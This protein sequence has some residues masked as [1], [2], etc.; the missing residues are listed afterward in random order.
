MKVEPGSDGLS[1]SLFPQAQKGYMKLAPSATGTGGSG[2]LKVY[3][4]VMDKET[5]TPFAGE[6]GVRLFPQNWSQAPDKVSDLDELT[7]SM[8]GLVVGVPHR[9]SSKD[10]Q[11]PLQLHG[12]QTGQLFAFEFEDVQREDVRFSELQ[13]QVGSQ[14]IPLAYNQDSGA[15]AERNTLLVLIYQDQGRGHEVHVHALRAKGDVIAST[16]RELSSADLQNI[17]NLTTFSKLHTVALKSGIEEAAIDAAS[18]KH[19]GDPRLAGYELLKEMKDRLEHFTAEDLAQLFDDDNQKPLAEKIRSGNLQLTFEDVQLQQEMVMV[20]GWLNPAASDLAAMLGMSESTI[21]QIKGDSNPGYKLLSAAY[22]ENKLGQIYSES[23]KTNM[24]LD[25]LQRQI[26]EEDRFPW[27][28]VLMSQPAPQDEGSSSGRASILPIAYQHIDPELLKLTVSDSTLTGF[29]FDLGGTDIHNFKPLAIRIGSKLLVAAGGQPGS[30]RMSADFSKLRHHNKVR[31]FQFRRRK[32][33]RPDNLLN[34]GGFFELIN[35]ADDLECNGLGCLALKEL[36]SG[37][38]EKKM[39]PHHYIPLVQEYVDTS[40]RDPV[41]VENRRKA[42]S[43]LAAGRNLAAI[44]QKG[45]EINRYLAHKLEIQCTEYSCMHQRHD[46]S[47]KAHYIREC[48]G[49]PTLEAEISKLGIQPYV[50][51][52]P[53]KQ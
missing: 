43:L 38:V 47:G 28:Q 32:T 16:D 14:G 4:L 51:A 5:E 35:A 30:D 31:E 33:I 18:S 2:N 39:E 9:I 21:Q 29:S 36:E 12:D 6:V 23:K 10:T 40:S 3:I 45:L 1:L 13:L 42:L 34:W 46:S 49:N 20:G 53:R 15:E 8:A 25:D 37:K 44:H 26:E 48:S 41:P 17:S 24:A 19:P 22:H 27:L 52:P 50:F 7:Q 11:E